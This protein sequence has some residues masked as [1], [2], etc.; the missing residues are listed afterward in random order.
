MLCQN[1]IIL[2]FSIVT[3]TNECRTKGIRYVT[4]SNK[5]RFFGSCVK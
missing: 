1:E 2:E 5:A 3:I 4:V